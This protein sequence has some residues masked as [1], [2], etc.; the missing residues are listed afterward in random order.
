MISGKT[1]NFNAEI[2]NLV[3]FPDLVNLLVDLV[4]FPN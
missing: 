4:I 2:L 3:I 1:G